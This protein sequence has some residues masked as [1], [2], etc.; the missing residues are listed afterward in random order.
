GNALRAA[1][2]LDAAAACFLDVIRQQPG[3]AAA[4]LNLGVV[5]FEQ[6]RLA[7]A[8]AALR[9]AQRL[10]PNDALSFRQLALVLIAAG[11]LDEAAAAILQAVER[12]RG[13]GTALDPKSATANRIKLRHDADQLAWLAGRGLLRPGVAPR[14]ARPPPA[15]HSHTPAPPPPARRAARPPPPPPPPP[16]PS[17]PTTTACSM[18]ARRRPG[19]AVRS[20]AT[21]TAPRWRLPFGS[22]SPAS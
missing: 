6:D 20:G 1:G 4:H 22:G 21:G 13:V 19:R 14:G 5:R 7:E 10:Y 18:S 3:L 12:E 11:R 15:P 2:D 8:E 16:P 9:T 17:S